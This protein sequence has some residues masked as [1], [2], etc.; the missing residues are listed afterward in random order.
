[1]ADIQ[2]IVVYAAGFKRRCFGRAG[3][4][5]V[6]KG[7]SRGGGAMAAETLHFV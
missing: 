6:S 4:N 3:N 5:V 1:M 7:T 2:S